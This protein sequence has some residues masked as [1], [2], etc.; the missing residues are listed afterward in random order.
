MPRRLRSSSSALS[1]LVFPEDR[2][3][4]DAHTEP[5]DV[6][7]D[8]TGYSAEGSLGSHGI[9]G[10]RLDR[11]QSV[12]FPVDGRSADACD[13]ADLRLHASGLFS[14]FLFWVCRNTG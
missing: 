4:G 12:V 7:C 13:A 14:V 3:K 1:V 6:L 9:G 8:I 5:G 11:V 2:D 10:S